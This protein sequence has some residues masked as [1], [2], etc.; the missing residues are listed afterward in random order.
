MMFSRN[1]DAGKAVVLNLGDDVRSDLR[2]KTLF[3]EWRDRGLSSQIQVEPADQPAAQFLKREMSTIKRDTL[4]NISSGTR[5][6]TTLARTVM[7]CH[8]TQCTYNSSR[9]RFEELTAALLHGMPESITSK[10]PGRRR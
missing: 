10:V 9:Y 5:S 3:V 2:L 4:S 7:Q 1:A 6:K 8:R